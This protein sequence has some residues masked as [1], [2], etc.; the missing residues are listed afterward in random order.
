MAV[1]IDYWERIMQPYSHDQMRL[2]QSSSGDK[3]RPNCITMPMVAQQKDGL[4]LLQALQIFCP[5]KFAQQRRT[6]D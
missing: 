1:G 4:R 3:Q 5:I 2:I 6:V